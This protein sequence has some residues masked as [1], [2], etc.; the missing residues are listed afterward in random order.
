[1]PA[2]LSDLIASAMP[3][4]SLHSSDAQQLAVPRILI[5]DYFLLPLH[6]S[7]TPFHL[8]L[9]CATHYRPS[10]NLKTNLFGDAIN[11]LPLAPLHYRTLRCY[12]N[13]CIVIIYKVQALVPEASNKLGE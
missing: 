5:N 2:Y 8:M 1:M 13:K 10:N 7:G 3:V 6:K 12:A 11:L 4:W 9:D